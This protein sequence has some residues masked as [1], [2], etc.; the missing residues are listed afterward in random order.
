MRSAHG[1]SSLL[2]TDSGRRTATCGRC[3][4]SFSGRA[5]EARGWL[6]AHVASEHQARRPVLRVALGTA[7]A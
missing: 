5:T 4:D 6:E 2:R 7:A 1:F 3:G